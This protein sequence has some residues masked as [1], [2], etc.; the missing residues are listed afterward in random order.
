M[1]K[2]HT[3]AQI[4][5]SIWF[6]YIRRSLINSGELKALIDQGIRGVT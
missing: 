3:L 6:D 2:L 1:A 5:Q 4:G